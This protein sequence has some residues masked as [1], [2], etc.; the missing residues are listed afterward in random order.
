MMSVAARLEGSE[1]DGGIVGRAERTKRELESLLLGPRHGAVRNT[2][3]FL[4]MTHDSGDGELVLDGDRLRVHWPGVAAEPIFARV[5]R[6]LDVASRA[7]DASSVRDPLSTDLF[8]DRLISVHPLGGC[9][10]GEDAASGAVDHKGRVFAGTS[11]S[12]THPGLYVTDGAVIPRPLGVNPLLTISALA[13]RSCALMA[14]DRGWT[15]E[16]EL[17]PP[18]PAPEPE[19]EVVSQP[20]VQFT[21]RMSGWFSTAVRDDY[22]RGAQVGQE[23]NSSIEFVVTIHTDDVE[24][25]ISDPEHEAPLT[26]T[27]TAPAL[28]QR[29][30]TI[31]DGRFNLFVDDPEQ[32]DTRKMI[33]RMRVTS[34]EGHTYWFEGFKVIHHDRGFDI[35]DDTTTLYATVHDGADATAPVLGK[36][37]LRITPGDFLRQ[38]TTMRATG[39]GDRKRQLETKARFGRFFAGALLDVYGGIFSRESY[40]DGAGRPRKKRQLR[41]SAP[42]IYPVTTDD[43]VTLRLTRYRGG[44]KG[45]L[46]LAHGLGVSSAIFTID[47]IETN[48]LEYVF[49]SGYDVW[50]LDYRASIELPSSRSQFTGDDVATRDFPAAV[51]AVLDKTG[52]DS[53]Q[54]IAHCFGGTTFTCALLAGLQGVRS[55]VISQI[56]ADVVAPTETRLKAGLH[57]PTVLDDIGIDTLTARASRH[58]GWRAK[59]FDLATTILPAQGREACPS[60]VCN[61]ISFMYAPL[62]RHEQLNEATHD[63]LGEMF[64]VAN[65][66][67]FEH[68]ALM[69]RKGH[70]VGADGSERY[71][72]HLQRMAIPICFIHGAEN[73]CYLSESITRTVQR[74]SQANGADLYTRHEIPAYGHI[75]CIFGKNAA[76]DVFP[77]M[78]EHLEKT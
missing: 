78:V 56:S 2:Q 19:P 48:L 41:V 20:G 5:Q 47:T 11:G 54:V 73:R 62:Y 74:L 39:T 28:S 77:L 26:G 30:L 42:E 66:E 64:G 24:R 69:V 61:R 1:A 55:A 51:R 7:I 72:P 21:E 33:Y 32:F 46:L 8:R 29:P 18:P 36:G 9:P 44:D 4:V 35:W 76:R 59:V 40:V 43:G 27:L 13:E 15:I 31:S 65:I 67:S 70:V 22:A 53:L 57:M 16:Y 58:E 63:A 10:M 60:A 12:E 75:D 3:T 49:A 25:M 50:L 6:N 34:E 52:A 38:L 23:G 71:M 68:L 37:I 17:S 45:P 14:A